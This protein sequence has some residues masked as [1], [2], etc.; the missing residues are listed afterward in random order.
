[1]GTGWRRVHPAGPRRRQ[2]PKTKTRSAARTTRPAPAADFSPSRPCLTAQQA[3]ALEPPSPC[4]HGSSASAPRSLLRGGA[5]PPRDSSAPPAVGG[6]VGTTCCRK[7][8]VLVLAW[9]GR[10]AREDD[11][12]AWRRSAALLHR[13]WSEPL[14][15]GV[16]DPLTLPCFM[17]RTRGPIGSFQ[18]LGSAIRWVDPAH[19]HL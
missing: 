11:V 3:A 6:P 14:D 15:P 10:G 17:G 9:M 19:A 18:R 1:M 8:V 2:E 4:H 5:S 7:V 13:L 12:G 16:S